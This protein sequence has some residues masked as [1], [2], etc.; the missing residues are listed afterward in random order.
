MRLKMDLWVQTTNK[1]MKHTA[2]AYTHVFAV[3]SF[4]LLNHDVLQ[5]L[6][7]QDLSQLQTVLRKVWNER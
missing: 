3:Q 7:V 6:V 5:D 2:A 1:D 4:G